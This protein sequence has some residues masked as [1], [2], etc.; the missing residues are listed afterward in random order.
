MERLWCSF[1]FS[2][3]PGLRAWL[4][5]LPAVRVFGSM[6]NQNTG[7][8]VEVSQEEKAPEGNRREN[9]RGTREIL[10]SSSA[11]SRLSPPSN[12]GIIQIEGRQDQEMVGREPARAR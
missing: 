6:E 10:T 11:R 3:P 5:K 7:P 1:I 12:S 8:E 2:I 9:A 4:H